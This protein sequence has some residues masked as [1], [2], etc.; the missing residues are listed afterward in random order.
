M[1]KRRSGKVTPAETTLKYQLPGDGTDVYID[2]MRD[3]SAVNRRG[4]NQGQMLHISHVT[5]RQ[6]S[7]SNTTGLNTTLKVLPSTWVAAQAYMKARTAWNRQ[8][9]SVRKETGQVAIR[10]AYEDFKVFMDP[11]MEVQTVPGVYDNILETLDGAGTAVV[12]GEWDYSQLVYAEQ[13]SEIIRQPYLHMI[14]A[15]LGVASVGLINAYEDSRA[16]VS[17]TVPNVPAAASTNIYTLMTA[18]SDEGAAAEIIENMED[19]NDNPPYALNN[20]AGGVVNYPTAVD[21]CYLQSSASNPIVHSTS[22]NAM[23]GLLRIFSQ[24]KDVVSGGDITVQGTMLVHLAAGPKDG[25]LSINV[26]DL[27]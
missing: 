17:P 2:L 12:Q 6:D 26:G 10:P 23:C 25:I 24:G 7:A 15:D 1:A 18:G 16:T 19:D 21:T 14:G 13:P 11:T 4:M 27:V 5:I 20:Y 8:Q 3:L 22:F 9:Y